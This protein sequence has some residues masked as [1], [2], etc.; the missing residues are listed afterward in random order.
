[1]SSQYKLGGNLSTVI[2]ILVYVLGGIVAYQ[3][4]DLFQPDGERVRVLF[5]WISLNASGRV[6]V[7]QLITFG[8]ATLFHGVW[9]VFFSENDNRWRETLRAK[10]IW[11]LFFRFAWVLMLS[12][13]M[14]GVIGVQISKRPDSEFSKYLSV[15]VPNFLFGAWV[16]SAKYL[17]IAIFKTKKRSF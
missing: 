11:H 16:W 8:Y 2:F 17:F 9:S 1:V 5:S 4:A 7:Y 14:L 15:L 10:D 3:G 12:I 6:P 13:L